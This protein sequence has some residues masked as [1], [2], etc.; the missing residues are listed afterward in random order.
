MNSQKTRSHRELVGELR[1]LIPS[2]LDCGRYELFSVVTH[3]D[4]DGVT[5]VA[6]GKPRAPEHAEDG[7]ST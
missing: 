6:L 1:H 7:S 3:E 5:V 2:V 4:A